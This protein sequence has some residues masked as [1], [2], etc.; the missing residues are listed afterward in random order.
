MRRGRSKPGPHKIANKWVEHSHTSPTYERYGTTCVNSDAMMLL[1]FW[2][3]QV[4]YNG[5]P[6]LNG[7]SNRSLLS[8]YMDSLSTPPPL[9][10]ALAAII[11]SVFYGSWRYVI[12]RRTALPHP[13]GPK[14]L[15]LVGN[16]FDIPKKHEWLT[17]KKYTD[18]YGE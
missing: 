13:P 17:Y 3:V 10:L 12:R 8:L 6:F 1:F 4:P 18:Q 2:N 16:L 11:G 14:G 5:Q 7:P 9:T 15:P